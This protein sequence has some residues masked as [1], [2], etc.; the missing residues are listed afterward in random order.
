MEDTELRQYACDNSNDQ[1]FDVSIWGD[2]AQIIIKPLSRST[3]IGD[4]L[5]WGWGTDI[6]TTLVA[7]ATRPSSSSGTTKTPAPAEASW[8]RRLLA[9]PNLAGLALDL[10]NFCGRS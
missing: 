1:R 2:T 7:V 6:V 8:L 9:N 4:G 5:L 3:C 10:T